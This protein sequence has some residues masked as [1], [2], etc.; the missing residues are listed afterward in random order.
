[1]ARD[2]ITPKLPLREATESVELVTFTKQ[3]VTVANGIEIEKAFDNK[4]NSL[5]IIVEPTS[6]GT[7]TFKAGDAYP[8]SM[9]G[10]LTVTP[11]DDQPNVYQILDEAR[12]ERTDGSLYIDFGTG[13]V[14]TIYAVAKRAGIL[15]KA[16]Q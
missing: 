3:A 16:N 13:F 4:N 11:T 14:G 8:N 12:F 2:K 1:M 6:V 10:D 5:F 15:P 7:I 9:L